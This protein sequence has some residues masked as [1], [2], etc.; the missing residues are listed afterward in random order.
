ML[1][2][3]ILWRAGF[4]RFTGSI[5]MGSV[6]PFLALFLYSVENLSPYV[7][8]VIFS[9]TY[10]TGMIFQP[11]GGRISDKHG[12]KITITA[13]LFVSFILYFAIWVF[14]S[15][16]VSIILM[17]TAYVMASLG[18]SLTYSPYY[19]LITKSSMGSPMKETFGI[20]RII[21]N[22]GFIIGPIAGSIISLYRFSDIFLFASIFR[23]LELIV[24]IL[25][26]KTP[27]RNRDL[28]SPNN[29]KAFTGVASR[30]NRKLLFFSLSVMF[31]AMMGTQVQ[32]SLP[33]FA[34]STGGIT[35]AEYGYIYS[36]NGLVVVA[37]QLLINRIFSKIG[38]MASMFAGIALYMIAF[39]I[40]GFSNAFL[41]LVGLIVIYSLGE[42]IVAPLENA[43]IG[44]F[45]PLRK[46]G[47]YISVKSSF[48]SAG[49]VLGPVVGSIIIFLLPFRY[50]VSWG[51]MDVFGV[52]SMIMFLA[53]RREALKGLSP[54]ATA[55]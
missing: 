15:S 54:L 4:A 27:A 35:I 16:G 23:L 34:F 51:I 37:G 13:G 45:A 42:D 38:D 40:A 48:W 33:V 22:L 55:V 26:V 32:V 6:I 53:F 11:I 41:P 3:S 49:N 17:I 50:L 47:F 46:L 5:G 7:I 18:S 30:I 1:D 29:T 14:V 52:V 10:L 31:L 9:I 24:L 21:F 2:N 25:L 44:S 39:I 20:F 19:S 36:L 28:P 8:G 12:E 43:I